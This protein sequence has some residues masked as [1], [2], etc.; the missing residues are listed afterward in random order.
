MDYQPS[1]TPEI[2]RQFPEI[3]P[4]QFARAV[5]LI[6]RDGRVCSGAE[7]VFRTIAV[8]PKYGWPLHVYQKFPGAAAVNEV[9]YNFV[10]AHRP[11]F[12]LLTRSLW[13]RH[14]ELPE[15]VL[16]RWLFLR[17]LGLVYLVA[18]V[19]LW[20][21]I[22]GLIGHDGILPVDQ[23]MSS[24]KQACDVRGI[25]A[26]RFGMVPTLCWLN[27]S[28]SFL[29]I[30]CAAGA[31][32]SA[33][34]ILDLLPVVCLI[35]LWFLYLSLATVGQD[36]LS[37][38][39]D[40]L[41]LEAG[42]LA[43]FVAP[44]Q[45]LPRL[46]TA[47]PPSRVALWLLRL[48]LFKLMFSSGCVKLASQ[49]PNWRNL[50]ALTFHYHTQP[51]PTWLAWYAQQLP[52][53]FQ[54]TSCATLFAIEIGAPFLIFGPRRIRFLGA[55]AIA[56]LQVLILLTGN[57]TF[58]NFLTLTL[59]LLLLD[60]FAFLNLLP[61]KAARRFAPNP[62]GMW[63]RFVT[64]PVAI[65][66]LAISSFQI[67]S[68]LGFSSNLLQP[69]ASFD[70]QIAPLRT[71]NSYGL[72]AVMT[73]TRDEIIVQGSDDGTTWLD[74]E[75]KYKPGDLNQ[76]PAFVAP[77]QPRLDWQ[78]WFAALGSYQQNPWFENFCERLLEGSAPVLAL[79]QKNPFPRHPPRFI[80]AELYEY[81][82][83]TPAERRS[84]GAWWHREP[85]G[86]YLPP[87][88]FNPGSGPL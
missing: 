45:L 15:H 20:M 47:A 11:F 72:F 65:I 82:F 83:T 29:K 30:Q 4:E 43:I 88:A 78:M 21:Q 70:A 25:G 24:V 44:L 7:A 16:T 54:K 61:S 76:R 55:A 74:Y 32:F 1:Q 66:V 37:F 50:T 57:Y 49:D 18:F 52:L 12:S 34:L 9:A 56:F 80:R 71:V 51:L 46:A 73:T 75:F 36:F 48:L 13:G 2:A 79:L 6:D 14:V 86:E 59:C 53:W 60:D 42:F 58:F 31:A 39:W 22:S 17:A 77:F 81:R 38:Q 33:L 87:A 26:E 64:I 3:P 85:V 84:S 63:P 23:F 19:S 67:V 62:K 68:A 41:L 35:L 40:G 27:S 28:D 69:I 5:Q 8:N 10:A